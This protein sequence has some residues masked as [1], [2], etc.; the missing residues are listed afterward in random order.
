M[1]RSLRFFVCLFKPSGNERGGCAHWADHTP[2][3]RLEQNPCDNADTKGHDHETEDSE[4][5][6]VVLPVRMGEG[7]GE[8]GDH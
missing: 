5:N 8:D 4:G 2:A 1:P 6:A 7:N 3:S